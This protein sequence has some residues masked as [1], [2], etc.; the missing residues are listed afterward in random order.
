A[1]AWR[2]ELAAA[3]A[4]PRFAARAVRGRSLPGELELLRCRYNDIVI[5]TEGRDTADS[6]AALIAARLA[7]VPVTPAQAD[8]ASQYQ[9]IARLNAARMFNPGLRVLFVL[10]GGADGPSDAERATVRAYAAR[11]MAATLASTIIRGAAASELDALYR[12]V[13]NH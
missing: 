2:G 10:V 11:V 5:D 6:R 13:F 3:G 8:L 1:C 9:L 12:E 4:Q 7:V